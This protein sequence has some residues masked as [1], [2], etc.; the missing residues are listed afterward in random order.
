MISQITF[1][2]T[3][4]S[5]F[6]LKWIFLTITYA[7]DR[8]PFNTKDIFNGSLEFTFAAI[9]ILYGLVE[10]NAV[11]AQIYFLFVLAILF[12][13]GLEVSTNIN[14][15]VYNLLLCFVVGSTLYC[16]AFP[17][18]LSLFS[19]SNSDI[20]KKENQ[21]NNLDKMIDEIENIDTSSFSIKSSCQKLA[22]GEKI[23]V[24]GFKKELK[25][26]KDDEIKSLALAYFF[27]NT[28]KEKAKERLKTVNSKRFLNDKNYI[29]A[30]F[31]TQ[32]DSLCV[33]SFLNEGSFAV[34]SDN[35][36]KAKEKVEK[37]CKASLKIKILDCTAGYKRNPTSFKGVEL[38]KQLVKKGLVETSIE[39]QATE[40]E[41]IYD[42]SVFKN[43]K[44]GHRT[45]TR[46]LLNNEK[47][48]SNKLSSILG[49]LG[50]KSFDDKSGKV[51]NEL[52]GFD[53]VIVIGE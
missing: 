48:K 9:G 10:N 37:A 28:D 51:P 3:L 38:K 22:K 17:K 27:M 47:N 31:E 26:I 50:L 39:V 7:K 13:F 2:G 12:S 46:Y 24:E 21:T 4:L 18:S 43:W 52:L 29:L 33:L 5:P 42:I 34:N 15:L 40:F 6:I 49:G 23:D 36:E 20:Q 14:K 32:S 45:V 30:S 1:I 44:P 53:C 25:K 41:R 8:E 19:S 35:L 11:P 16:F